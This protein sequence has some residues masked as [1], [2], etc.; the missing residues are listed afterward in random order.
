MQVVGA[1]PAQKKLLRQKVQLV[2]QNPYG[3]LNPR[4]KIG[5]A[6]EDVAVA[7]LRAAGFDLY[8]RRGD[9]Q[10]DKSGYLVNGAG[11]YL[12]G[13]PIDPTTGNVAPRQEVALQ[14]AFSI[15]PRLR[16]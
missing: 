13:V 7:W 16:P 8:T 3:S 4:Q 10:I 15:D 14:A 6:L 1:S 11:Y 5:H 9:F 2:F 12:E